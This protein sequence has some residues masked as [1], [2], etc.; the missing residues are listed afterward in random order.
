MMKIGS[1]LLLLL[2]LSFL[3]CTVHKRKGMG[4]DAYNGYKSPM[5][6]KK[7]YKR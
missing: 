3:S 1:T 5:K 7:W 6:Y 2:F 4:C